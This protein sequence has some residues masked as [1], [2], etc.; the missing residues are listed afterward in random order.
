MEWFF[1]N[2]L[3]EYWSSWILVETGENILPVTRHR[4][5]VGGTFRSLDGSPFHI[6][7]IPRRKVY[8]L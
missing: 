5:T 6:G 3:Q 2:G 1:V 8:L 4:L 7:I